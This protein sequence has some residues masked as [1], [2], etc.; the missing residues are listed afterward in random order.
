MAGTEKPSLGRR[1]N[2]PA[3]VKFKS[4]Y[5]EYSLS[6]TLKGSVLGYARTA[7]S[8]LAEPVPGRDV[9][10]LRDFLTQVVKNDDVQLVFTEKSR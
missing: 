10:R 2:R 1:L 7:V 3:P 8:N 6:F 5:G 4:P 9:A